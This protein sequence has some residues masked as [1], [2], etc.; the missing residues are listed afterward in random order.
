MVDDL[1]SQIEKLKE[2]N[3]QIDFTW[4]EKYKEMNEVKDADYAKMK[5]LLTDNLDK[6]RRG[7]AE[8]IKAMMQE[9]KE[10]MQ[11]IESTHNR[12]QNESKAA[13]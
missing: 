6:E 1:T 10:D 4:A 9:F 12:K 5:K 8:K 3:Q 2:N 11:T 7:G 13:M